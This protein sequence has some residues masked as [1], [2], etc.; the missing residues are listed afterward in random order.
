MFAVIIGLLVVVVL[1]VFLIM[2]L[3]RRGDG[4]YTTILQQQLIELRGRMDTI[5]SAQHEVPK[6]LAEGQ[7]EQLRSLADVQHHLARLSEATSRLEGV[8]RTVADVQEL[9]K[10]PQLR[11]TLG[12]MWLEELLRHVFPVGL[13]ETQ[14][15]F[16]SGERVDA[17][18]RIGGRLVPIDS[19]FPLE[20]CER[21]LRAHGP[22]AEKERRMF[23]QTLRVRIDEIADRYIR[24]DEGT[25]DFAFMYIPAENVYYEAVVRGEQLEAE[26]SIVGYALDRKVIPVSPNTFYAYL[27]AV[28]HGLKGLEVEERAR[29]ILDSLG[30]LQHQFNKFERAYDLVGKHLQNAA[31]QYDET[32]RHMARMNGQFESITG[33]DPSDVKR[34]AET[35]V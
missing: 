9:L 15:G 32:T 14:Y 17:V 29:E 3:L 23:R 10:V 18:I 22:D 2:L 4:G 7:A 24:P 1:L 25:Y 13:Y 16:R 5:A 30:A 19:K 27:S 35:G 20:A 28:L 8:G 26:G 11:G 31:K 12:E 34:V 21:M 6:T 33:L